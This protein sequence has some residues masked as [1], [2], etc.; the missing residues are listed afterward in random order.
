MKALDDGGHRDAIV[1]CGYI[2]AR[3]EQFFLLV[4]CAVNRVSDNTEG[5][6]RAGTGSVSESRPI[7]K[8]GDMGG[9]V[10]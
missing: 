5:V 2:K 7:N 6:C 9:S 3:D 10:L 4:F 1:S 8:A